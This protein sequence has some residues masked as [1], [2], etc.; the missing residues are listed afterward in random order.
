M[1]ILAW[2]CSLIFGMGADEEINV[3]SIFDGEFDIEG[4]RPV[5]RGQ[6]EIDIFSF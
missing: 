5:P 4:L 3:I 1:L 6:H 2:T